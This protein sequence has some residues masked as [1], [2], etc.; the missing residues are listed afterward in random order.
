MDYSASVSTQN[1]TSSIG[2]CGCSNS[3]S[4]EQQPEGNSRNL[5]NFPPE[6]ITMFM[7]N[8]DARDLKALIRTC[9]QFRDFGRKVI[10]KL[11]PTAIFKICSNYTSF[12]DA[13]TDL[14]LAKAAGADFNMKQRMLTWD[15][16]DGQ[17]YTIHGSVLCIAA[18]R[19]DNELVEY[20]ISG[21]KARINSIPTDPD[22]S[23]SPL[24]A[25]IRGRKVK[26]A[27]FLVSLGA[28]VR[29]SSGIW[30]LHIAAQ[31][32]LTL[33]F[34]FLVDAG[35]AINAADKESRTP[36]SYA[37]ASLDNQNTVTALEGLGARERLE[38]GVWK[39]QGQVLE[40]ER[41]H[42]PEYDQHRPSR[43]VKDIQLMAEQLLVGNI[44]ELWAEEPHALHYCQFMR[45]DNRQ[46]FD[47]YMPRPLASLLD[48]LQ[49]HGPLLI[50]GDQPPRWM[51]SL[52]MMVYQT[53]FWYE[54]C[55]DLAKN[56]QGI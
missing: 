12:E 53:P 28:E 3:S 48:R 6:L 39:E 25:A 2:I 33:L 20:L 40:Q 13:K 29:F 22:D 23:Y 56:R 27:K 31:A 1:K 43:H 15:P 50:S 21:C 45:V 16:F 42:I 37:L 5:T 9:R 34:K 46:A 8:C 19:G 7:M 10:Y 49:T 51:S 4:I 24:E 18:F 38:D 41:S 30:A 44:N 26:T 36:L 55:P 54:E 47:K 11:N 17:F 32:G 35:C 14:R 52:R